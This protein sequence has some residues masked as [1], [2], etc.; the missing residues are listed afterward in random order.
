MDNGANINSR[1]VSCQNL[2]R[3]VRI[4]TIPENPGMLENDPQCTTR[5]AALPTGTWPL[6]SNHV[7]KEQCRPTFNLKSIYSNIVKTKF[8]I[9]DFKSRLK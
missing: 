3:G 6:N 7:Q 9:T 2:F 8:S 1:T 4:L 5:H